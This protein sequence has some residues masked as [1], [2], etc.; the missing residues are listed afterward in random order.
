MHYQPN[1]TRNELYLSGD[2]GIK[3]MERFAI[4]IKVMFPSAEIVEKRSVS[5]SDEDILKGGIPFLRN[6]DFLQGTEGWQLSKGGTGIFKQN[7]VDGIYYFERVASKNSGGGCNLWQE[8]IIPAGTTRKVNSIKMK[9]FIDRHTLQDPGW[10]SDKHGGYYEYPVHI[11]LIDENGK[12]VWNKG[13]ITT[14]RGNTNATNFQVVPLKEW[15]EVEFNP[16]VEAHSIRISSEGWDFGGKIDYI[17][18]K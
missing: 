6:W 9:V 18:L 5:Q 4:P 11:Y 3:E 10:W 12:V 14:G 16:Q 7:V 1:K 2:G 15:V 8:L 13:L 17:L